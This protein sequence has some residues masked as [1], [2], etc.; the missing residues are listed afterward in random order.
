LDGKTERLDR[1]IEGVEGREPAEF[2]AAHARTLEAAPQIEAHFP[3]ALE[4]LEVY[5][6]A[7]RCRKC[8][9]KAATKWVE[10]R[11]ERT[12][13]RCGHTTIEVPLDAEEALPSISAE[14]G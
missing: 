14:Q 8:G 4:P 5:D 6:P 11:L 2:W 10:D 12:C 7:R 9:G 1:R 3:D 13:R